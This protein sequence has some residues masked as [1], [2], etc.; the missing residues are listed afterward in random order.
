MRGFFNYCLNWYAHL[1]NDRSFKTKVRRALF[2]FRFYFSLPDSSN[3]NWPCVRL[4]FLRILFSFSSSF[5]VSVHF[6]RVFL[7]DSF[8]FF[9]FNFSC[10][11]FHFSTPRAYSISQRRRDKNN[12]KKED[13]H[14]EK[15]QLQ[16]QDSLFPAQ[17]FRLGFH[18]WSKRR[19]HRRDV[20]QFFWIRLEGALA[21]AV[22]SRKD[23]IDSICPSATTILNRV[24]PRQW[25]SV[26]PLK[27]VSNYVP[28]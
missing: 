22:P 21:R 16:Y 2:I 7:M 8:I 10:F 23:E 20:I 6:L 26:D 27:I 9:I 24:P 18:V 1:Y 4:S 15:I 19:Q 28:P 13:R 17:L 3:N 5:C 14:G 12:R 25:T 11:F